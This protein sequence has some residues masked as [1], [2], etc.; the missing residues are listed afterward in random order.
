MREIKFR[1]K[2]VRGDWVEGYYGVLR[3]GDKEKHYIMQSIVSNKDGDTH[4][5]FNHIQVDPE[6]VG[7]YTELRDRYGKE[8]YD[9]D[10]IYS[11]GNKPQAIKWSDTVSGWAMWQGVGATTGIPESFEIISNIHDQ[12][13]LLKGENA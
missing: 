5:Y 9:G 2:D 10:I 7:Q 3:H 11:G 8:A 4:I 1:G 12:P 13:H 6:T